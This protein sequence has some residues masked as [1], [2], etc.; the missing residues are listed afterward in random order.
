MYVA[1]LLL[2]VATN[3]V[4]AGLGWDPSGFVYDPGPNYTLA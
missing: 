3:G 1:F 2:V 4:A